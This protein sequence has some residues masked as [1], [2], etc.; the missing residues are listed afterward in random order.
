VYVHVEG[1]DSVHALEGR[2]AVSIDIDAAD[3]L[4][5]ESIGAGRREA[6]ARA[7]ATAEEIDDTYLHS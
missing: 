1:R 3:N 2:A 5:P 7:S 4:E 6:R